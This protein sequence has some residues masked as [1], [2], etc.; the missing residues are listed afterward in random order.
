MSQVGL[1]CATKALNGCGRSL[2]DIWLWSD[3]LKARCPGYSGARVQGASK[4][5][6]R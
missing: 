5:L 4:N 2:G 6:V 1:E 3:L